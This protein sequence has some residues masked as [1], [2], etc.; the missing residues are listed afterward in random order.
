MNTLP[1]VISDTITHIEN[2]QWDQVKI[3]L[4]LNNPHRKYILNGRDKN[5]LGLLYFAAANNLP[6]VLEELLQL[7]ANTSITKLPVN[8]SA[9]HGAAWFVLFTAL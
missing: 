1:T 8:S 4:L 7:G 3:P 9:L 5:G 6:H 2:G